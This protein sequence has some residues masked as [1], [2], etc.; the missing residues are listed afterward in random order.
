MGVIAVADARPS[1]LVLVRVVAAAAAAAEDGLGDAGEGGLEPALAEQGL[2]GV[3]AGADEGGVDLAQG[4]LEPRD[5]FLEGRALR[6][7]RV[8]RTFSAFRKKPE[9]M[10]GSG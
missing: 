8:R 1:E 10:Q 5:S 9:G 6:R 2:V 4:L 3:D 7:L